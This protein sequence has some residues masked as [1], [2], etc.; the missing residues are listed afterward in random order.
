M[1]GT[2]AVTATLGWLVRLAQSHPRNGRRPSLERRMQTTA[3]T[4]LT[5]ITHVT[6]ERQHQR[7]P[8][9]ALGA[10]KLRHGP[11]PD[12]VK[13]PTLLMSLFQLVENVLQRAPSEEAL[14]HLVATRPRV[15][16]RRHQRHH[17]Y[18]QLGKQKK[19]RLKIRQQNAMSPR[20]THWPLTVRSRVRHPPLR[21]EVPPAGGGTLAQVPLVTTWLTLPLDQRLTRNRLHQAPN[22]ESLPSGRGSIHLKHTALLCPGVVGSTSHPNMGTYCRTWRTLTHTSRMM[23]HPNIRTALDMPLLTVNRSTWTSTIAATMHP[24][25]PYSISFPAP[26]ATVP[27]LMPPT[28]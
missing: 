5:S 27:T 28:S 15:R 8:P 23:T 9:R 2:T 13:A 6:R 11:A 4:L 18:P 22:T 16:P 14:H 20:P 3:M 21:A 1:T 25:D 12:H 17:R 26:A 10:R 7:Q 24:R 19:D